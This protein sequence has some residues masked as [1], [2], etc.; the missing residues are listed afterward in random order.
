MN[1]RPA[2]LS[3]NRTETGSIRGQNLDFFTPKI[4]VATLTMKSSMYI[5]PLQILCFGLVL[6]TASPENARVSAGDHGAQVVVRV[7]FSGDRRLERLSG[8]WVLPI[9]ARFGE[10][11]MTGF[12]SPMAG[13]GGRFFRWRFP[14]LLNAIEI[15][16]FRPSECFSTMGPESSGSMY[17]FGPLKA[18]IFTKRSQRDWLWPNSQYQRDQPSAFM[19]FSKNR[20]WL[21]FKN[22]NQ[23]ERP[24]LRCR[25]ARN[26]IRAPDSHRIIRKR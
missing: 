4:G 14:Q 21:Y 22:S 3:K 9:L 26:R 24:M 25:R 13:Q 19:G 16:C 1:L 15:W 10:P 11:K 17:T 12:W 8:A 2:G 18:D 20:V 6:R 5:A 23:P 7:G